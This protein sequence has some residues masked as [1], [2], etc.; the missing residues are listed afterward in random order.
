MPRQTVFITGAS[1]GIGLATAR[2]FL[3][4]DWNV[5]ATMRD[6]GRTLIDTPDPRRLT[7][8]A[9]DVLDEDSI[10][11]AVRAAEERH[12]AIDVLVNNAGY[13]LMGPLEAL[14]P[15][16]LWRQF[17]TNVLGLIAT[18]RHV[19]PGMRRRR[20]GLVIN[21]GSIG[22]RMAFPLASAYHATKF[23]VEG[24]SESLRFELKA[25]GIRVKV[26]E[27]GGI[28][29]N[30]ITHGTQWASHAAYEPQVSAFKDMSLRLND[31]LPGPEKVA[32]VV[33][34]AATDP[35]DRLRYRAAAGPYPLMRALLPDAVW[36]GLVAM[37]LSRQAGGKRGNFSSTTRR[38]A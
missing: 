30:F 1:S 32:E 14:S 20:S 26:V 37:A 21:I 4:E 5:V 9:V 33:F 29:T 15:E 19:L 22:G 10:D 17:E 24:L 3:A 36:R 12:G 38:E 7:V 28:R 6:P 31:R 2:H 27:P 11:R 34:R 23:A 18:T 8:Q 13:A 25:H 16:L 35:S